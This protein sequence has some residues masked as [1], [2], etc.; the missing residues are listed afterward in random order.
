VLNRFH[1]RDLSFYNVV[2]RE[3]F[4]LPGAAEYLGHS[5]RWLRENCVSLGIEHV[6]VGRKFRF[7]R[8]ELER[9]LARHRR[10]GKKGVYVA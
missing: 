5:R 7:T 1:K 9:F 3:I 6:R 2:E 8:A 10:R 4:D